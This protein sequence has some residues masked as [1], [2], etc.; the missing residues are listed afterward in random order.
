MYKVELENFSGP[1]DLLLYFIRRDKIDIY[2]IPISSITKEYM[3]T[4]EMLENLN[5]NI[6]GEF[7]LMA[8]TLMSIKAK[9]LLPKPE[10]IDLDEE[11]DPRIELV[12][13]LLEYQ[14][15]KEMSFDLKQLAEERS[16]YHTR[17]MKMRTPDYKEHI[18]EHLKD[19]T[20]FEIARIFK[21]AM[22]N[23]PVIQP[24]ELH[25]E[26]IHLD[27]QK[28][29]ILKSFDMQGSLKFSFLLDK[30]K[31]KIEVVVTFLAIL[32]LVRMRKIVVIQNKIFGEM[33]MQ[34]IEAEA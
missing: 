5:L 8:A 29:I 21:N 11:S 1:L 23:M 6:A 22:E 24:Y 13:Q 10:F 26:E 9:M 28:E 34:K 16:H 15:F 32:E 27:A 7:I 14:R 2:D 17:G 18:T 31:S 25:R 19:V 20:I 33:E 12:Q 3:D 30:L 4:L